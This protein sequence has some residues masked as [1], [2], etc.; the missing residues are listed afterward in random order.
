M[1]R[2]L[3]YT[4]VTK[5][6]LEVRMGK[7]KGSFSEWVCPINIGQIL[8]EFSFKSLNFFNILNLLRKCLKRLPVKSC[9]INYKT[10]I[11]SKNIEKKFNLIIKS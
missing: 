7:G 8:L 9:L 5:K 2:K 3:P 6:P 1:F 11:L 10:G 4:F